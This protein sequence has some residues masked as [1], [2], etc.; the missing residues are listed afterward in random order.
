M[1]KIYDTEKHFLRNLSAYKDLV[2]ESELFN[3]DKTLSFTYRGKQTDIRNEYYIETQD[4]WYVVKEVKPQDDGAD[5]VCKL[6]LE[7]LEADVKMSF[8]ATNQTV[9]DAAALALVGTGGRVE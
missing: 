7:E 3:G 1:I 8:T 5:Y 4:D 9:V 6:N 2:I